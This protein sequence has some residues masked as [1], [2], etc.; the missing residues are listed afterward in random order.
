MIRFH[1]GEVVVGDELKVERRGLAAVFAKL[2]YIIS[3]N[4]EAYRNTYMSPINTGHHRHLTTACSSFQKSPSILT[5]CL[6]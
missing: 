3:D 6:G 4:S 2:P 5:L 1:A